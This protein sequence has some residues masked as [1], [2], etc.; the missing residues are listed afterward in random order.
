MSLAENKNVWV[1][2]PA[3][4]EGTV[5]G[6]VAESVVTRGYSVVVVDD[7]STDTTRETACEA[8]TYTCR[9]LI[10]LGQGAALQTG[11]DFAL[12][13]GALVV[14]TFD[15][16]GQHHAD[17]IENLIQPILRGESD[18]VLGSRFAIGGS[19]QN[20]PATRRIALKLAVL[21]T[22]LTTGLMLTDTHNGFRALSCNAAR[23]IKFRQNRMAHASEILSEVARIGL[24]YREIPVTVSYDE[25]SLKKGQ[26]ISNSLNVLWESAMERIKR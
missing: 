19:A 14:V 10:N 4:N 17:E 24:R 7:G 2:I 22:K 12:M 8:G 1:V 26:K 15:A 20:I 21:F 9:H 6:E 3:F 13:M 11:I 5:V 16:D 18:V 23:A 25:Y